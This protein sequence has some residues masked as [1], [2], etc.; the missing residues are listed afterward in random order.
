[1]KT[2]WLVGLMLAAMLIVA[3]CVG[4]NVPDS[5]TVAVYNLG[6]G[7][8]SVSWPTPGFFGTSLGAGTDTRS[9][10]PCEANVWRFSAGDYP[11]TI[12]SATDKV[13]FVLQAAP[14]GQ[15]GVRVTYAIDAGGHI[16]PVD[17]ATM[18]ANGACLP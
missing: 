13:T 16:A 17:P 1:M 8:G 3:G 9:M 2:G 4:Y 18:P 14:N 7:T 15:P 12:T 11:I 10:G 5:G 6:H